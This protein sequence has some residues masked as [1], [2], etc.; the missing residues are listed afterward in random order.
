M[1]A[2]EKNIGGRRFSFGTIPPDPDGIEIEMMVVRVCGETLIKVYAEMAEKG[3]QPK[4]DTEW[5]PLIGDLLPVIMSRLHARDHVQPDGARVMGLMSAMN[6]VF[7]YVRC[8]GVPLTTEMFTGRPGKEKY[9]VFFEALKVNF[10]GFFGVGLSPSLP[11][12]TQK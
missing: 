7:K 5:L 3:D 6:T 12:T 9:A 10:D 8:E 2:P 11:D 4:T 1:S